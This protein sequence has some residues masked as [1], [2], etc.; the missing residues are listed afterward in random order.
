MYPNAL[1]H[2]VEL[3]IELPRSI[4]GLTELVIRAIPTNKYVFCGQV[5][6][7]IQDNFGFYITPDQV[8]KM[9]WNDSRVKRMWTEQGWKI[10]R[11]KTLSDYF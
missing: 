10:T 8:R 4:S 2:R 3:T 5:S 9:A 6:K 1:A 11:T 7:E